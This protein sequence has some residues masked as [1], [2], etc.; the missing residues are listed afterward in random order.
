M[1]D[2]HPVLGIDLNV[3]GSENDPEEDGQVLGQPVVQVF[4]SNPIDWDQV[5]EDFFDLG[6]PIFFH[7]P[8]K[9]CSITSSYV[10][11]LLFFWSLNSMSNS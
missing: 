6:N 2:P 7:Q 3:P 9:G 5:Q 11:V 1:A 4:I 8:E 10:F